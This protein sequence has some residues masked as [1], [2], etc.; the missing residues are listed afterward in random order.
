MTWLLRFGHSLLLS[1]L[2]CTPLT[3]QCVCEVVNSFQVVQAAGGCSIPGQQGTVACVTAVLGS[4]PG[5]ANPAS[6]TCSLYRGERYVCGPETTACTYRT[7]RVVMTPV[8]CASGCFGQQCA[9]VKLDGTAAGTVCSGGPE[10]VFDVPPPS[11]MGSECGTPDQDRWLNVY[12]KDGSI[13]LQVRLR[14][15]CHQ[16]PAITN[17]G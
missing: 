11:N 8:S 2:A 5:A 1:Y 17:D 14:F 12:A 15:G 7:I 16:C 4:I 10:Q 13:V 9:T 6:G 3:S